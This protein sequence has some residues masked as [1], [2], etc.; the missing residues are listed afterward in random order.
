MVASVTRR[1][2][3]YCIGPTATMASLAVRPLMV[4]AIR[5]QSGKNGVVS[6]RSERPRRI[7]ATSG[8]AK[9]LPLHP[10]QLMS[11]NGLAKR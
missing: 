4:P 1:L 5:S 9:H 10:S 8:A 6:G 7:C 11:F 3:D 2:S